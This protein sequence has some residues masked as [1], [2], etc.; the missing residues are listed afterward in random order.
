[1]HKIVRIF[2]YASLNVYS[3]RWGLI[4]LGGL[5]KEGT[6]GNDVR[7]KRFRFGCSLLFL[8]FG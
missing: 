4:E 6:N 7:D 5:G 1:M 2:L 3:L 8:R